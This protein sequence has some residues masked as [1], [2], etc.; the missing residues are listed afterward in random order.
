MKLIPIAAFS[1]VT[2]S[3]AQAADWPSWRGPH[4]DG[5]CDET[6][7]PTKWSAT[8]NLAW[9]SPLPAPGNSTPIVWAQ[10]VFITQA[11]EGGKR[12]L[13]CFDRATGQQLWAAGTTYTEPEV[14]HGTNPHCSASPVTDGQRVIVSFA[15][16]GVFCYDL[17]GKELWHRDLGKQ[18]HIWGNG[19]SPVLAGGVC[20]L[21]FGPGERTFLIALD[22]T[23][24]KTLWQH[25]EPGGAS[26]IPD[27]STP[28]KRTEWTGSWSDPLPRLIHG[29]PSLIMSYPGR[30]C[31][32]QAK[33]GKQLWTCDGL[34]ALVYTSPL[35]AEKTGIAVGMS[36]YGGSALAVQV[37][38][39]GDITSQRL[40]HLPKNPQRIA[41]GVIHGEHIYIHNDPGT[42][43]CLEL[44]TGKVLYTERLKGP[45]PTSQNW[46]SVVLADG[47]CYTANQGGDCFVWKASPTF[48]LVAT[49]SLGEKVIG[50]IA[51]SDGQLFIRG[52]KHLF[53]V[54]KK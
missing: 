30:L 39:T 34:T 14:T 53:C 42:A 3:I 50:S 47:L 1:L 44:K 13:L 6:K 25:E 4:N 23:T 22:P 8:D 31:A 2:I 32:F 51:V 49:N 19:A 45:A 35:Y 37:K 20:Y 54:G 18:H 24:G 9:S 43:T 40:W 41:S 5:I 52:H 15:S 12:E 21:N 33:T 46:S 48:E 11:S 27:P 38:G 7:L 17:K 10:Q 28:N 16:A 26:G 36:G 29:E